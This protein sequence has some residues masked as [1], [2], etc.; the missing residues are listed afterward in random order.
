MRYKS[1]H[2]ENFKSLKSVTIEPSDLTIVLGP[3]AAGKSNLASAFDFLSDTYRDGLAFAVAKKGG[4][5]NIAFRRQRRTKAAIKFSV[6][7]ELDQRETRQATLPFQS[8]SRNRVS[9]RVGGRGAQLTH[10]FSIRAHGEGIRSDFA[11]ESEEITFKFRTESELFE[12]ESADFDFQIL[13]SN[14][15]SSILKEP[16]DAGLLKDLRDF[17]AYLENRR[18]DRLAGDALLLGEIFPRLARLLA[19]TAVYQFSPKICRLPAAPVP[20]PKLSAYGENLPALVDWLQR[21]HPKIWKD[22]EG[23][24]RDIVP[25]LE[26]VQIDY[27]HTK[28]L[29]IFIKEEGFSR[30]WTVEDTSDGTIQSLAVLTALSDP[31]SSTLIVEEPENSIHP[32]I[33][34]LLVKRM[35]E[36]SGSRTVIVTTHSPVVIDL[37]RPSEIWI[38][39][40]SNGQTELKRLT[41]LDPMVET[42]W[43]NGKYRLFEYLETGVVSEVVPSN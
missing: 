11:L 12:S 40:K 6:V 28:T 26:E 29:G 33:T 7:I 32:W 21:R 16:K 8:V 10:T 34:K 38:A 42:D 9:P 14:N 35:R 24:M 13:R 25:G 5:E 41:D 23:A 43:E 22:V 3:N 2:I 27:L 4:Y 19:S 30:P 1:I 36:I 39:Y 20:D 31:R 18:F 37:A 17:L 15:K